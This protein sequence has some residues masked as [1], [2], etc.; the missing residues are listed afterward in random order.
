MHKLAEEVSRETAAN[1]QCVMN[2]DQSASAAPTA[3]VTWSSLLDTDDSG[4]QSEF[5]NLVSHHEVVTEIQEGQRSLNSISATGMEITPTGY[6]NKMC[7]SMVF[8]D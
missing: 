6:V 7:P 1:K 2:L 8:L 3:G 4:C 5:W